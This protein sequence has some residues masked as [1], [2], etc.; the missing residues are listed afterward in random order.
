MRFGGSGAVRSCHGSYFSAFCFA[1]PFLYFS[2][3]LI[4][5]LNP[6]LGEDSWKGTSATPSPFTVDVLLEA[7]YNIHRKK[8]A[9]KDEKTDL[10][11]VVKGV[12]EGWDLL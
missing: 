9:K 3:L 2:H 6:S 10:A 5:V 12:W 7:S 11:S 4:M 1:H 8:K